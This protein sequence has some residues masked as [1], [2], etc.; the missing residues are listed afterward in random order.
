MKIIALLV[1]LT[2]AG[3]A[4]DIPRPIREAPAGNL[5]LAQALQNP[6]PHRGAAVRWGGAIADLAACRDLGMAFSAG[7]DAGLF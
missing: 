6:E 7:L 4:S 3:C 2:L 5:A 1:G